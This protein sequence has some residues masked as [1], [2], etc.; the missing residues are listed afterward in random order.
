MSALTEYLLKL[1]VL[2]KVKQADIIVR[3][4]L[5][6]VTTD[7]NHLDNEDIAFHSIN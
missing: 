7:D 5:S 6:S 3:I 2:M 1:V 4:V